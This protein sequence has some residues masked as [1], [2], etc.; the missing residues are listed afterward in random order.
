MRT[1]VIG[2]IHGAAKA[3]EDLLAKVQVQPDDTLIFLGD[4]CDG[5]PET[6]QVFDIIIKLR[7][8]CVCIRGNHD[9]WMID[10]QL[11]LHGSGQYETPPERNHYTQGGKA[12][13][14]AYMKFEP[15][16]KRPFMM[17]RDTGF[18]Y[19]TVHYFLDEKNRLF[20][21]GGVDTRGVKSPEMIMMWDRQL[22]EGA[23]TI[24]ELGG[25]LAD[26][27]AVYRQ[28]DEIYVGHTATRFLTNTDEPAHWLNLWAM[29]TNCG[30]GGPLTAMDVDTK[31]IWQSTPARELYPD[32]QP[33]EQ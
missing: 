25:T 3:L 9:Q 12:T 2:D 10:W 19:A 16:T 28:F 24:H 7:N 17:G 15:T 18:L 23:H 22:M 33:R 5:Y 32:H 4:Y 20:V 31:Q 21:H 13:Y 6:P 8:Q 30:W 27:P 14:D 11:K 1:I 26:A 29:D